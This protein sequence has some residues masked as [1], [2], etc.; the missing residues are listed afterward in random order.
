MKLPKSR[1]CGENFTDERN[2]QT[3]MK[4]HKSRGSIKC[5]KFEKTFDEDWKMRAHL[6]SHG[7]HLCETCKKL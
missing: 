7:E 1:E 5:E 4:K 6:K 2:L 3:H